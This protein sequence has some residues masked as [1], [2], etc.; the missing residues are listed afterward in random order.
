MTVFKVEIAS[1]K[2]KYFN[3]KAFCIEEDIDYQAFQN[4]KK[5]NRSHFRTNSETSKIARK[6]M[7]LGLGKWIEETN[8]NKGQEV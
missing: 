6:L 3:E 4:I 2:N 7:K 8:Q 5:K 1:I